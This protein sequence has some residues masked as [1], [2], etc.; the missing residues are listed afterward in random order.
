MKTF[1]L[2]LSLVFTLTL[3][4]GAPT[5]IIVAPVAAAGAQQPAPQPPPAD[6]E[7]VPVTDLSMQEQLP[8]APLVMAAYAIAWVAIFGYLWSVWRRLAR[9]EGEIASIRRRVEAGSRPEARG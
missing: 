9:V 3:A 8:A 1:T 7:F 2:R 5:A 4:I 6:D